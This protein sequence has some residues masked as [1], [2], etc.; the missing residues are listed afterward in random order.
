MKNNYKISLKTGKTSL[1]Q[2][3]LMLF[4]IFTMSF[5][6]STFAQDY[7]NDDFEVVYQPL[8][9]SADAAVGV[10]AGNEAFNEVGITALGSSTNTVLVTMKL[11]PGVMYI[12]GTVNKTSDNPAG[13]YSVSDSDVYD[14]K[15]NKLMFN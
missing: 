1:M 7:A 6:T 12:P 4:V 15:N 8:M 2:R 3:A 13:A 5:V 9:L 10:G 14:K 11:P